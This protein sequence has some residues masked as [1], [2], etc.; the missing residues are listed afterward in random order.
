[1]LD[2]EGAENITHGLWIL[3]CLNPSF[4]W[5]RNSSSKGRSD[6][7]HATKRIGR[8]SEENTESAISAEAKERGNF[9]SG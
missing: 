2:I 9:K 5:W 4:Y 6:F 1:M 7:P 3:S 8:K